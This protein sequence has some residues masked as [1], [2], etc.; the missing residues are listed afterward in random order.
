MVRA[1]KRTRLEIPISSYPTPK[2][3]RFQNT[4]MQ[5]KQGNKAKSKQKETFTVLSIVWNQVELQV[6]FQ[7]LLMQVVI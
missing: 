5:H 1:Q 7:V 3:F 2:T 6:Q 4:N